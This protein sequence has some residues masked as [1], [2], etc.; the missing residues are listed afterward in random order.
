MF[1]KSLKI[2]GHTLTITRIGVVVSIVASALLAYIG[3]QL[4]LDIGLIAQATAV[5]FGICAAAFLPVYIG[6]LFVRRLS[7]KAAVSSILTGSLASFF[8]IFFVHGKNAT[9]I[10]LCKLLFGKPH[11]FVDTALAKLAMVDAVV[12]AVP[13]SALVLLVAGLLTRPDI[14]ETHLDK[15]FDGVK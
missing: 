3:N 13:L 10:G 14:D 15:C 2:K 12:I 4:H 5:F 1:E 6:A 8:W 11:L 9:T 7:R